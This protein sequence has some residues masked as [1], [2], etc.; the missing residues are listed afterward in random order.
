[1][2]HRRQQVGPDALGPHGQRHLAGHADR[3][4]V[5]PEQQA[6][7]ERALLLHVEGG[8]SLREPRAD[9]GVR[10]D[11]AA[12]RR[13]VGRDHVPEPDRMRNHEL[14]DL[15]RERHYFAASGAQGRFVSGSSASSARL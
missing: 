10:E 6:P 1:M 3:F 14:A 11:R 12:P 9:G 5:L 8:R 7:H 13:Q 2:E 15:D 4:G